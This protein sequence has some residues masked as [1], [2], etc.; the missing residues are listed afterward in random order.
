MGL[1]PEQQQPSGLPLWLFTSLRSI[2][3]LGSVLQYLLAASDI[4][5]FTKAA[6]SRPPALIIRFASIHHWPVSQVSLFVVS[7][8]RGLR[9]CGFFPKQRP[10]DRPLWLSA[11]VS[12]HHRPVTRV[13]LFFGGLRHRGFRQSS[14]LAAD[15]FGLFAFASFSSPACMIFIFFF[16]FFRPALG[17][18]PV[19][20]T[21]CN[22]N[23]GHSRERRWRVDCVIGILRRRSDRP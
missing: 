19:S 18:Q 13:K 20:S 7:S 8:I 2:T 11:F 23:R 1:S 10:F 5:A 6:T 21:D 22:G 9:H 12:I 3:G 15:R 17:A 4:A 16:W 14:G